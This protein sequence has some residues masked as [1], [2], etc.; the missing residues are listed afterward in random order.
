MTCTKTVPM[1]TQTAT[2]PGGRSIV[3]RDAT[4]AK[5]SKSSR[6]LVDHELNIFSFNKS[7]FHIYSHFANFEHGF[8]FLQPRMR[9]AALKPLRPKRFIHLR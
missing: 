6:C 1:D 2:T 7:T 9:R 8:P 3:P 4:F 5:V